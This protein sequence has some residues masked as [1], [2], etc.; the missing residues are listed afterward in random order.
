VVCD[1][2]GRVVGGPVE[3]LVYVPRSQSGAARFDVDA[4]ALAASA[5]V[6]PGPVRRPVEAFAGGLLGGVVR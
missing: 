4:H 3:E 2:A 1:A 6:W 5:G